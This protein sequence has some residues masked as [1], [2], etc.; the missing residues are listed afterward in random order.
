MSRDDIN[1]TLEN[2]VLTLEAEVHREE[3]EER[4]GRVIRQE[5]RYGKFMRS[6]NLG[7][8][9]SE[10]E[11][12]ASFKDGVLKLKVPKHEERQPQRKRIEIH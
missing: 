10:E 3:K 1:V 9:V 2:G 12:D 11:I 6:F 8:D 4:E 5:R 7:E